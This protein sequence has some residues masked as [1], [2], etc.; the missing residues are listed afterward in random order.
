MEMLMENA[1]PDDARSAKLI[2]HP[3][4]VGARLMLCN[5]QEVIY[6]PRPHICL[7]ITVAVFLHKLVNS[8]QRLPS[9]QLVLLVDLSHTRCVYICKK[10]LLKMSKNADEE[11]RQ[12][13]FSLKSILLLKIWLIS[14]HNNDRPLPN[15]LLARKKNICRFFPFLLVFRELTVKAERDFMKPFVMIMIVGDI[16][17]RYASFAESRYPSFSLIALIEWWLRLRSLNLR[18]IYAKWANNRN[19]RQ[20]QTRTAPVIVFANGKMEERLLRRRKKCCVI[21]VREA[22]KQNKAD[23]RCV[24][25]CGHGFCRRIRNSLAQS[26]HN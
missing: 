20:V 24:F 5:E 19:M 12:T 15:D 8:W 2:S 6:L 22:R 14:C 9:D 21:S 17:T 13:D 3:A 18:L 7:I 11:E 16:M 25:W 4:L 26:G 1:F 10:L 23:K